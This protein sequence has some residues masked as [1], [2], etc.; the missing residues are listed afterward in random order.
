MV[1]K[2]CGRELLE[3]EK[4]CI[5]CGSYVDDN[6][7][8]PQSQENELNIDVP[9]EPL[10]LSGHSDN[11]EANKLID[12]N[13]TP[14][15]DLKNDYL[16]NDMNDNRYDRLLEAYVG[17]DYQEIVRKKINLYAF[18]FNLFYFLYRKV[19]SIGIVGLIILWVFAIKKP[20]LI[21]PYIIVIAI[22][23]GV[24][25]NPIYLKLASNKIKKLRKA[26]PSTDDFDLMEICRKKGGVNVVVALVIYLIFIISIIGTLF[27]F[28]LFLN[29]KEK[30]W[31]ENNNNRANC[32]YITKN[33]LIYGRNNGVI[34]NDTDILE[35]ACKKF[36]DSTEFFDI[37]LKM[38]N[39]DGSVSY[40][41]F[42]TGEQ[43][44]RLNNNTIQKGILENKKNTGTITEE[45]NK[46]L[47]EYE[48]IEKN[49]KIIKEDSEKYEEL[50]SKKK[51]NTERTSFIFTK[52]EVLR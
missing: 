21:I 12:I 11:Y 22:I 4:F 18:L 29:G 36:G 39:F 45:E 38:K 27:S 52:E 47:E 32:I 25:F 26:N 35:T 9:K 49:Y 28:K 34:S 51:N 24:L 6:S 8:L 31:E 16:E 13:I 5:V 30:Y 37:Y 17:E 3:G 1:C 10:E 33:S 44:L 46:R 23:S 7:N 20:I 50:V 42:S 43:E 48:Q 40:L 41:Y 14:P 2:N 15:N 19:Y